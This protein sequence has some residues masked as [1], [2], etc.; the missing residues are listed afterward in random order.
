MAI[1]LRINQSIKVVRAAIA[2]HL[3]SF[4]KRTTGFKG[5]LRKD[6]LGIDHFFLHLTE[7]GYPGWGNES[8]LGFIHVRQLSA[9]LTEVV[10]EDSAWLERGPNLVRDRFDSD[11][12]SFSKRKRQVSFERIKS[13]HQQVRDHIVLALQEDRLLTPDES[14]PARIRSENGTP[15]NRQTRVFISYAHED[16]QSARKIYQDLKSVDGIRPWFDKNDLLPGMKWRP[17]IKK[18]IRESDFFL[19][20]LSKRSVSKRGY[21]Q[22][23]MKEAFEIWDQFPEDKAFLIPIRLEDCDPSYEKLREVQYQD[24][25]PNWEQGIRRVLNVMR[26]HDRI[27]APSHSEQGGYE[28]RCAIVDF[29]NGLTNLVEICRRLNSIQNFFHFSCPSFRLEHAALREFD[30]KPNLYIPDLPVSLYEQK[31]LLNADLVICLTK[32]PLAFV[33]DG[34]T[35]CD[36]LSSPSDTDETFKIITTHGLYHFAKQAGCRFEKSIVYHILTQLLIHFASNLGFHDEVRGCILDFC[37]EHSWMVKGMKR[38]RLCR[39]CAR[40]VENVD[41]KKA[42]LAILADP[43]KV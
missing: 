34:E 10:I 15:V 1:K 6:D 23:E 29:D 20:L 33:E 32:H 11:R 21:V 43:I 4:Q 3:D 18:A 36:Y 40:S 2:T 16:V 9:K 17:A 27:E 37:E 39:N 14:A 35:Y 12:D 41:L 8:N 5:G 24:F 13:V 19:A 28:Y 26:T 31:I 30:G 7:P 42:V 38:M 25:F 22:T